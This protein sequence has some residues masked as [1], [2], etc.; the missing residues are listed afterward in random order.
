ME[1]PTMSE[2][3]FRRLV[4]EKTLATF[5]KIFWSKEGKEMKETRRIKTC[6]VCHSDNIIG[7]VFGDGSHCGDCGVKFAFK[8]M[9]EKEELDKA[10]AALK[11]GG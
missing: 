6:P 7:T 10:I 11:E 1:F 2:A 3:T 4:G 9:R 5:G 8:S